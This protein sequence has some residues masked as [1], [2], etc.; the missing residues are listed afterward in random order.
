GT[1]GEFKRF[2]GAYTEVEII[3]G[4]KRFVRFLS[5][6]DGFPILA[7]DGAPLTLSLTSK[8]SRFWSWPVLLDTEWL[9][10]FGNRKH[11]DSRWLLKA[12]PV[13][14]ARTAKGW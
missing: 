1:V 13:P 12:I 7:T 4:V 3:D 11:N 6:A 10:A 9:K 2:T 8:V 14:E 5:D